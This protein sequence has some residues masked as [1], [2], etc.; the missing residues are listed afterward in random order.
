MQLIPSNLETILLFQ[1][2]IAPDICLGN[3]FILVTRHLVCIEIHIKS[4]MM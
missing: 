2:N 4:A 1:K 3:F